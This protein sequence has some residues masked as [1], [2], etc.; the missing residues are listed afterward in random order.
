MATLNEK[1]TALER[2]IEYI[3]ARV[4]EC[5]IRPRLSIVHVTSFEFNRV[6]DVNKSEMHQRYTQGVFTLGMSLDEYHKK[7]CEGKR[8]GFYTKCLTANV[9]M[10]S[11]SVFKVKG[12]QCF[13]AFVM[14]WHDNCSLLFEREWLHLSFEQRGL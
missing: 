3:E 1:L 10:S 11:G 2:R 13:D 8:K 9:D 12:R 14:K 7:Q 6:Q 4:S 5:V